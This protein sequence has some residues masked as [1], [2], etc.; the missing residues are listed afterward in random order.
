MTSTNWKPKVLT[1]LG[2]VG[3]GKSRHRPRNDE[4]LYGGRFPFIQTADVMYADPYIVAHHQTYSDFGLSQSKLWPA[5]TLCITIAGANTAETAILKFEACFPDSVVGFI[6]NPSVAD[7]RFVKYAL[8][9]MKHRFLAVTRGATQDNLSLDKL[10]S[11][12]ILTPPLAV[13]RRISGILAAYDDLIAADRRR[14]AA[15]H[16]LQSA[17]F[18]EWFVHLRYPGRS[19]SSSDGSAGGH[20][21]LVG[22]K[23]TKLTELAEFEKG[24]EPGARVYQREPGDGL[25]RF[26]R[27]GNFSK[28]DALLF[29]PEGAAKGAIL[30]A[31]DIAITLDGSVGVVRCGLAG[32]FSSG[33]RKVLI[34]DREALGWSFAFNLLRS[35][36]IQAI[37]QAHAKGTTIKHAGTAVDAMRFLCPPRHLMG[38][39]EEVCGPMLHQAIVLEQRADNA[40]RTRDLLLPRLVSGQLDVSSLPETAE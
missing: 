15:L 2:H 24:V 39:F 36:S 31:A 17:I 18:T 3:R 27:V 26:L 19:S 34:R 35:Q 10:L 11:F 7:L 28:R 1:D 25:V 37:V 14:I 38:R 29:I 9:S 23:E 30:T 6:P 13:Q 16:E 20:D 12:P 32:A 8:D 40:R 4:R 21:S 22:W 5:D 33:I